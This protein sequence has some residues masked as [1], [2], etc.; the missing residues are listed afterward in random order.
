MDVRRS[1]WRLACGVDSA[2]EEKEDK[3]EE[4]GGGRAETHP[5]LI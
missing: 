5:G 2:D 4:A 1:E 3:E